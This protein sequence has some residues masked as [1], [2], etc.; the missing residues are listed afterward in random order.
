[1]FDHSLKIIFIESNIYPLKKII[2]IQT[3]RLKYV[4]TEK[5]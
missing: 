3:S 5:T 1:M 2:N 4:T